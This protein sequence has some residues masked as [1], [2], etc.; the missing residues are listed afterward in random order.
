[1]LLLLIQSFILLNI[2]VLEIGKLCSASWGQVGPGEVDIGASSLVA[3]AFLFFQRKGSNF[4]APA[5]WTGQ[6]S[7]SR[8]DALHS[9]E[10]SSGGIWP[11][12]LSAEVAKQCWL[13]CIRNSA[14]N[15]HLLTGLKSIPASSLQCA[16]SLIEW[17][18]IFSF[19]FCIEPQASVKTCKVVIPK[20]IQY[21]QPVNTS[22]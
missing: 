9:R 13:S 2:N 3:S 20:S 4:L 14:D 7:R 16:A 17:K 15:L 21:F 19:K 8:G 5:F 6:P 22:S 1:M 18:D 10:R 11:L 12:A